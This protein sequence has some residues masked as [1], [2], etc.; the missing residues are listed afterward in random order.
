MAFLYI[1]AWQGRAF[2]SV[3][4]CPSS[5]TLIASPWC[6][7][8]T[9]PWLI[10]TNIYLVSIVGFIFQYFTM[11]SFTDSVGVKSLAFF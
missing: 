10:E 5:F 3:V 2:L 6:F 11:N 7:F 9:L 4:I 1:G 8:Y